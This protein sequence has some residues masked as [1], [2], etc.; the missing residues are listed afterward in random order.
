MSTLSAETPAAPPQHTIYLRGEIEMGRQ[1]EL[2]NLLDRFLD[3]EAKSVTVDLREVTFFDSTG[4]SF[5]VR[6]RKESV[7][8]GG[9][10]TLLAP[11]RSVMRTLRITGLVSAFTVVDPG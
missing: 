11:Q 6:L 5:L 7:A 3:T 1:R 2:L 8:R 9:A 10:V 4:C